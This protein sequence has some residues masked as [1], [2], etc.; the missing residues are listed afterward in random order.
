M[1]T[2]LITFIQKDV[3]LNWMQ[4]AFQR[5]ETI[6][7]TLYFGCDLKFYVIY[8]QINGFGIGT[9]TSSVSK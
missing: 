8:I 5:E 3:P 4:M 7:N 1:N 2:A 9:K 6:L